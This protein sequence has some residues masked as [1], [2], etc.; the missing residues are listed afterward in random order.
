MC[1]LNYHI[2][3]HLYPA[4]PWYNLP[5]LHRLLGDRLRAAGGQYC[6]SYF[7]FLRQLVVFL[8]RAVIP[9]GARVPL[10]LPVRG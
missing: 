4:V 3:H 7:R 5:K 10:E 9:G 6:E 2:E 1:N 8:W